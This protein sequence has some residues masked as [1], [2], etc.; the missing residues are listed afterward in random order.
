MDAWRI[1][2]LDLNWMSQKFWIG[3]RTGEL[4]YPLEILMELHMSPHLLDLNNIST[5]LLQ[6]LNMHKQHL[7]R[8]SVGTDAKEFK[9]HPPALHSRL[10]AMGESQV[11]VLVRNACAW[12]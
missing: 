1:P 4:E 8:T 7:L 11:A 12:L 6:F 2:S 9:T 10:E 5:C 3:I